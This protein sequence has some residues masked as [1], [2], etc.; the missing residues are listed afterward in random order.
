ML[1]E[2]GVTCACGAVYTEHWKQLLKEFGAACVC[3]AVY[4]QQNLC[5][6]GLCRGCVISSLVIQVLR[7]EPPRISM[8][9]TYLLGMC[10]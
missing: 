2:F 4:T 10:D 9:G 3:G 1:Q 6:T 7:G 5:S 8:Q